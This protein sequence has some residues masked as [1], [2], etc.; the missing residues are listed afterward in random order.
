MME[1]A[2]NPNI[3][4]K[5]LELFRPQVD[6]KNFETW[7]KPTQFHSF[8]DDTLN[9]AVPQTFF[10]QWLTS[11][12]SQN[13]LPILQEL[14]QRD[15]ALNYI[16]VE[17]GDGDGNGSNPRPAADEMYAPTPQEVASAQAN[18]PH[19]N[20]RYLGNKLKEQYVFDTFV[21]G[22]NNRFA[23]AAARAVADPESKAYNPLFIYGD[24]GLGKTHLMQAIGHEFKS[25]HPALKILYVTSEQFMA[26]FIDSLTCKRLF[27]FRDLF[28]T[29]DL[30]LIDDIQFLAGKEQTQIEFFH[31]FNDLHNAGKKI[32]ISSDRP[33]KE[34]AALEERLRSRFEWGLQVDI[35]APNLE[36]RIAIL[37]KKA[38]LENVDLPDDVALFIAERIQ[39]N[40]RELE[41]ALHR[42][43]VYS[44][45]QEKKINLDLT[46]EIMGH[47]LADGG[48][49]R[50]INS[51]LIQE[52]VCEYFQM[53]HQDLVGKVRE[54]KFTAPRHIAM[55]LMRDLTEMSYKEIAAEFGGRDHT[56]VIYATSKV[57]KDLETNSNLQNTISFLMKNIRDSV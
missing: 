38:F 44:R 55:Y 10:E 24:S 32:V 28:R 33:P 53:K 19:P 41:G 29:V 9:I 18:P 21:V 2:V 40:I 6:P 31:T 46:R 36:T 48:V 45:L 47:L 25:N 1:T 7:L 23:Y 51:D 20:L 5:A 50:R 57:K 17:P 35:Q 13:L 39:K 16:T 52:A 49:E 15:I 11:N 4:Q 27:D 37:Q 14:A 34:L 22:D 56:S 12:Y 54:K 3:W 8:D 43:K 30:L 42:L 26:S